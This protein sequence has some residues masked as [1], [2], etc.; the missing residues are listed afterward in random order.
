M[1]EL[2]GLAIS[3]G[4]LD[5]AFRRAKPLL[6]AKVSAILAC[7]RRARVVCSDETSVRV[8]GRTCWDWVIQNSEVVIHVIRNS[9]GACIVR[10]V[11]LPRPQV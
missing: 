7:L 6:D 8:D 2:F 5:T 1:L 11:I 3:E 10:E 4:A 9:R